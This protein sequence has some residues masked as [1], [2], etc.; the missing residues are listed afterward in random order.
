[1]DLAKF[2]RDV[3]DFPKPGILFKDITPLLAAPA[4][5][6]E[7]IER[8]ARFDFGRVDK[9]AA[10]ES[11]GFLFGAPLAMRLGVG[12][13]PVRKPGK[14]PWKTNRVEY[15]LEY[16]K[17][18]VEI[19]QD[20][21]QREERVLLVDDLLATGGTMGAGMGL[22]LGVGGLYPFLGALLCRLRSSTFRAGQMHT[23]FFAHQILRAN[24][25]V[26]VFYFLGARQHAR[27]FGVLR[28][29]INV[30]QAYRM[31]LGDEN[32]LAG[33]QLAARGH[34]LVQAVGGET[35]GEPIRQQATHARIVELEV[36]KQAGQFVLGLSCGFNTRS[37]EA[38]FGHWYVCGK[39]LDA[40]NARH[41]K[42]GQTLA[43]GCF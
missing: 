17:D 4:A 28:V 23:G 33:L 2:L 9:V 3:P 18:A 6:H 26:Q 1:M 39:G 40:V 22:G 34:G 29:K 8:L 30:V 37:V 41:F 20:A 16:G 14:L 24:L 12:F 19:H 31:A 38:Q 10:I 32:L 25:F 15:T 5:M 21:V 13:V 35:S 36:V 11:R 42:G 43:Q 27:L 7:A